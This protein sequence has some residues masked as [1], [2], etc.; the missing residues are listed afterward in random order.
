MA[1]VNPCPK[2]IMLNRSAS[3]LL[4]AYVVPLSGGVCGVWCQVIGANVT[5]CVHFGHPNVHKSA[6]KRGCVVCGAPF[7][8]IITSTSHASNLE[9][10]WL[11]ALWTPQCAQKCAQEGV[12]GVWWPFLDLLLGI[13][14]C[15]RPPQL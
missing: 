9:D 3:A 11:C 5:G 13:I 1:N 4:C 6:H 8:H 7:V 14:T 10:H 2:V 12:C 15:Q